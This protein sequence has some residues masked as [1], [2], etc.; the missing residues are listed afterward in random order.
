MRESVRHDWTVEELEALYRLPFPEL[1][2][3]AQ[4]VHRAWHD[5][6]QVQACALLSIKTGGCS[7]DCG[8]CP[9]SAHYETGVARRDLLDVD[10]VLARA[11]EA[12][13]QG[14]SR[15]CMGA[16]WRDAPEGRAFENVLRM[17]RGVADL[18]LEACV[19]LGMLTDEQALRL[20]QAGLTAY[21]HNLD[22]SRD[23]YGSVITTRTYDERLATLARVRDA[24]IS[25]CCGG[26][27][28]LGES[29][30]DRCALIAELASFRPQPESVPVN[31]LMRSP[32]TPLEHAAPVDPLDL[33]RTVAVTRIAVPAARVRLSA[34][35]TALSPESQALCFLAGA[36]SI[37]LGERLLTADNPAPL[38]DARLL[39]RLG[40]SVG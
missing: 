5:P 37:F 29:V 3:R 32:G 34:G 1:V 14:A 40:L 17:V 4:G 8:Y 19:T 6:A 35:R 22:T 38:E 15:F 16:A 13:A 10:D 23:H 26:I 25:V 21:N 36:N 18:G 33:V 28:G 27:V 2:Y 24:G 31:L 12:R 11:G 30:R 9:Q 39:E 7:E 20:K